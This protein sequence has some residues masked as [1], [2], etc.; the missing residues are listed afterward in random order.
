M[1]RIGMPEEIQ[2]RHRPPHFLHIFAGDGYSAGYYSYMWAEVLDADGFKAF[3]EA[4][5]AFDPETARRLYENIYSA[6]GTR[7]YAE[8]YRAF[9]GRDADPQALLEGRGLKVASAA[10][11]VRK[12]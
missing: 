10:Q 11:T 6:G 3:Q 4:G 5:D 2:M 9:R 7:D 8:A 12:R 1:N